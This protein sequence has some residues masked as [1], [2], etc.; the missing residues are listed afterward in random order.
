MEEVTSHCGDCLHNEFNICRA[1][2][3]YYFFGEVISDEDVKCEDYEM[4]PNSYG[5][6]FKKKS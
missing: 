5:A 3:G 4:N 6:V 1:Q 2:Y